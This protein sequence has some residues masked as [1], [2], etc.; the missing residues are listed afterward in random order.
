[1]Y[2]IYCYALDLGTRRDKMTQALEHM[3]SQCLPVVQRARY[4]LMALNGKLHQVHTG[5]HFLK[6]ACIIHRKIAL[7]I[8]HQLHFN[9]KS[10]IRIV[11][12]NSTQH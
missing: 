8:F 3:Q 2:A 10:V 9:A 11:N 5:K 12:G 1:M 6:L 7:S 4:E